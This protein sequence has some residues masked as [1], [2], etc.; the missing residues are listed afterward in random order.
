MSLRDV[1]CAYFQERSGH[2]KHDNK[3]MLACL[4][5]LKLSTFHHT[6]SDIFIHSDL[7]SLLRGI[8]KQFKPCLRRLLPNLMQTN[9]CYFSVTKHVPLGLRLKCCPCTGERTNPE[10]WSGHQGFWKSCFTSVS[11]CRGQWEKKTCHIIYFSRRVCLPR[12]L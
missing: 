8:L 5:Y 3:V 4:Y 10:K 12:R 11:H 9:Q 2:K 7:W 1:W 6:F